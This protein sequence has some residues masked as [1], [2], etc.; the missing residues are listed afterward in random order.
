MMPIVA[1][2][3]VNRH[4]GLYRV[5]MLY[6]FLKLSIVEIGNILEISV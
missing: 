4:Q 3:Y 6:S 5:G 1:P 2:A